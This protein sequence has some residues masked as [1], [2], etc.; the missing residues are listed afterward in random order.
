M[1]RQNKWAEVQSYLAK[2]EADKDFNDSS[3]NVWIRLGMFYQLQIAY[4]ED[5]YKNL[6]KQI[7]EDNPYVGSKEDRMRVF[8]LYACKSANRDLTNFFKTWGYKF[9]SVS[10][11]YNEI[12]AL[13]FVAPDTDLTQLED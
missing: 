7:R 1:N 3:T 10:N 4:G 9:S 6:H 12:A 8:M 11:V 5:F 2:A 13:G